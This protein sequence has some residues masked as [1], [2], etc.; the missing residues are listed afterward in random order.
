MQTDPNGLNQHDPG[1][2]LDSAKAD[3]S[4][5]LMF[6]KALTAVALLGT[7][8]AK[9]YSRG[10]WQHVENGHERYTAALLRHLLLENQ[11]DYDQDLFTRFGA[12]LGHDVAV[13]WNALARLEL[14]LRSEAGLADALSQVSAMIKP[15]DDM[16]AA[17]PSLW[18]LRQQMQ[19]QLEAEE[20]VN[21]GPRGSGQIV[22]DSQCGPL[23][24]KA[25]KDLE[26]KK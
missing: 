9:K 19:D 26:D 18:E 4:L 15:R 23:V 10:G 7:Y 14:R 17:R 5:L 6:G 2:K 13:A 25:I 21:I 16:I 1:A 24:Y 12:E 20:S 8:G 22:T 3:A 11:E